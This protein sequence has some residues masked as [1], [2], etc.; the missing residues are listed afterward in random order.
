MSVK[1]LSGI[2]VLDLTW[3]YAGPFATQILGDLGAEIIKIEAAPVG[4]KTRIMPPFKNG[5][6]GYFA[7]L[8]RGKKS[9]ALNLKKEKGREIFLEL[10]KKCDVLTE[11]FAPGA[12]QDWPLMTKKCQT[13]GMMNAKAMSP[14]AQNVRVAS[15]CRRGGPG[16]D[17][18]ENR[19]TA[20]AANVHKAISD[21]SGRM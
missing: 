14:A 1:P 15:G 20:T 11:N 10:A 7:T 4:D 18:A 19:F 16:S 21:D 17:G 12:P 13:I 2:K 8:N 6:S 9:L 3:V 5:Y